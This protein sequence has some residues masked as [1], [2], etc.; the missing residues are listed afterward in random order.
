MRSPKMPWWP[1]PTYEIVGGFA[2]PSGRGVPVESR[3]GACSAN[4]AERETLAIGLKAG[5]PDR[6]RV[7]GALC[8]G[9][10]F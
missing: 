3:C 7:A 5:F 1:V 10:L 9:L 4:G 6:C 2:R 8:R